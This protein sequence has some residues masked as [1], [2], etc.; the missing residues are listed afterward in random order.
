LK[1]HKYLLL[2]SY[3]FKHIIIQKK[4]NKRINFIIRSSVLG[5][6]FSTELLKK[7]IQSIIIKKMN[8]I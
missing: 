7:Y 1:R 5:V 6:Y 4:M 2:K 8:K 3:I